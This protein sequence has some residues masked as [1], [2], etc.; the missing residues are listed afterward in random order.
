MVAHQA[1]KEYHL[2]LLGGNYDVYFTDQDGNRTLINHEQVLYVTVGSLMVDII[3]GVTDEYYS[4]YVSFPTMVVDDNKYDL[5]MLD[6]KNNE[7]SLV[8]SREEYA[9]D[10][11]KVVVAYASEPLEGNVKITVNK[12]ATRLPASTSK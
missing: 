11:Y 1:Y 9:D 12:G 3:F 10:A 4:S 2:S 7:L 5:I 6:I 8:V